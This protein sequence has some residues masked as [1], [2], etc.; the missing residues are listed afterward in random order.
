LPDLSGLMPGFS[1][2]GGPILPAIQGRS[3]VAVNGVVSKTVDLGAFSVD[4][5]TGFSRTA[6]F[7]CLTAGAYSGRLTIYKNAGGIQEKTFAFTIP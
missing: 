3:I 2:F 4:A 1:P 7:Q 6:S 5:V